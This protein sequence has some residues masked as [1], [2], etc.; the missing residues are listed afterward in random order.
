LETN[1]C[2]VTSQKSEGLLCKFTTCRS[3]KLMFISSTVEDQALVNKESKTFVIPS[4]QR[5]EQTSPPLT[6]AA[7]PVGIDS[8]SSKSHCVKTLES[9]IEPSLKASQNCGH[10]VLYGSCRSFR[11]DYGEIYCNNLFCI[12]GYR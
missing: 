3:E 5:T 2:R 7:I 6:S 9:E 12:H 10:H 11:S 1:I 4:V 8:P